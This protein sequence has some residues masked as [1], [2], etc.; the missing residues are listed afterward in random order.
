MKYLFLVLATTLF[1][2]SCSLDTTQRHQL[3]SQDSL[4]A[5]TLSFQYDTSQVSSDG[6]PMLSDDISGVGS[7]R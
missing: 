2:Y 1:F 7:Y 4:Y 6:E 3:Q 5:D